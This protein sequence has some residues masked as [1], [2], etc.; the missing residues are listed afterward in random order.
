MTNSMR[1]LAKKSAK[2]S[3]C[4]AMSFSALAVTVSAQS[5]RPNENQSPTLLPGNSDKLAVVAMLQSLL[6]DLRKGHDEPESLVLQAEVA[7]V[8]WTVDEDYAR[9]VFRRALDAASQP[10]EN[11]STVDSKLREHQLEAAR[12]RASALTRIVRL[13][14]THDEAAARQWFEKYESDRSDTEKKQRDSQAQAELLAQVA[15]DVS[16]KNPEQALRLGITSLRYENVPSEIGQLLFALAKHGKQYSD[17]I[18]GATLDNLRRN[19]YPYNN[20]LGSLSNYVFFSDGRAF[21]KEYG[22]QANAV[23]SFL[24]DAGEFHRNEWRRAQVAGGKSLS[25]PGASYHYFFLARGIAIINA[26]APLKLPAFQELVAELSSGL[27]QQQVNEADAL[28]R[29][30]H[31]QRTLNEVSGKALDEQLKHAA[32][33]KDPLIRDN[34]W[35]SIAIGMMHA[36]PDR[37][38]SIAANID[39]PDLHK[40]TEDDIR[41][42][43]TAGKVKLRDYQEARRSALQLNNLALRARALAAIAIANRAGGLCDTELLSEAYAVAQKDVNRPEKVRVILKLANHFAKC[44]SERGFELLSAAIEVAN[45]LPLESDSERRN[46]RGFRVETYTVVGGQELTTEVSNNRESIA[47]ED[48]TSFVR[49][50]FAQAQNIGYQFKDRVLRAKYLITLAKAVLITTPNRSARN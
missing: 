31:Q 3:F 35:R 20:V 46:L 14:A 43:V 24:I 29:S 49:R 42:L 47:F 40:Q 16:E 11:L 34:L 19:G 33:E 22:N 30:I 15:L 38:L 41:L 4:V 6:D 7:D 32:N 18:F 9:S 27:T 2:L 36:E 10:L 28:A 23:V 44:K 45:K 13:F 26:N 17:P 1:V 21:S 25:S 50:D 37:A 8:I 39:D 5:P 48:V 12:R